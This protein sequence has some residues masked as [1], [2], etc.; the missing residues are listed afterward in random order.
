MFASDLNMLITEPK[1]NTN[2]VSKLIFTFL[3]AT[4]SLS[5]CILMPF[6]TPDSQA[7]G[8]IT[9][10]CKLFSCQKN[11]NRL[12]TNKVNALNRTN[13]LDTLISSLSS[14]SDVIRTHAS[15]DLG[16]LGIS[17]Q[18]AVPKLEMLATTDPSKWVRRSAVKALLKI[19]SPSSYDVLNSVSKNDSNSYVRESASNALSKLR[20]RARSQL[21]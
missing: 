3:F 14:S 6:T 19:G 5:S 10:E 2:N 15:T 1:L 21:K 13:K 7:R 12:P 8:E 17:A 11:K 20:T 16:Y 9:K 4:F 18:K